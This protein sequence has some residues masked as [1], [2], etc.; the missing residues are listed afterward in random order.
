MIRYKVFASV[1]K[2]DAL[3]K[4]NQSILVVINSDKICLSKHQGQFYAYQN[5]CPHQS[6]SLSKGTINYLGEII[7]PL[8]S[9]RFNIKTGRECQMR[10]RDLDTY[11]VETN[12]EGL[13][14]TI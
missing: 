2:A 8:H 4:E 12:K 13:F 5:N 11:F 7:C 9:Y 14:V 3:I 1:E 10:T 6:D